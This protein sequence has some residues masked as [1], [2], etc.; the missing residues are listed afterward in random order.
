MQIQPVPTI[1]TVKLP[2]IITP[3][4]DQ[5]NDAYILDDLFADCVEYELKIMNRWG[6]LIYTQHKGDAPFAGKGMFDGQ[7]V[8]AGVYFFVIKS[9]DEEKTGTITV[10]Y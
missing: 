2:N 5:V 7:T 6:S 9:G 10:S 8:S 4:G 1:S 3:N